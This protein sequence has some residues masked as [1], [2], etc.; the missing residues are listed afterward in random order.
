MEFCCLVY[1]LVSKVND[2]GISGEFGQAE[3]AASAGDA[4]VWWRKA[5]TCRRGQLQQKRNCCAKRGSKSVQL[6]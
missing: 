4:G 2:V 5:E 1:A 3:G 6:F